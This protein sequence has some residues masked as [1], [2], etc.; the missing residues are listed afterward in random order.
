LYSIRAGNTTLARLS[1]NDETGDFRNNIL[2][3]TAQGSKLALLDAAGVITIHNNLM[4]SG[5]INSH[6][7]G[8]FTGTVTDDG[9]S[10]LTD[11]PGFMDGPNYDFSLMDGSPAANAGTTLHPD[12]AGIH[13]VNMEYVI[14][15]SGQVRPVSGTM[16]IGGYENDAALPLDLIDPF[17]TRLIDGKVIMTWSTQNEVNVNGFVISKKVNGQEAVV[18]KK[19]DAKGGHNKTSY[20]ETDADPGKGSIVYM[21][22]EENQDGQQLYLGSSIILMPSYQVSIYPNPAQQLLYIDSHYYEGLKNYQILDLSGKVI[23]KGKVKHKQIFI[24]HLRSGNYILLLDGYKAFQF[25]KS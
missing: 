4:K 17:E 1:T 23:Q 12:A 25:I 7:G 18:L 3:V 5:W 2:F 13:D 20:T 24:N 21:L 10:V 8:G 6:Q 11:D 16:D 22:S 14:H 9:S 15:Q 19:I